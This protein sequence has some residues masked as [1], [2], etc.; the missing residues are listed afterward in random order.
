MIKQG[1][2]LPSLYGERRWREKMQFSSVGGKGF[3]RRVMTT[4]G[5][6]KPFGCGGW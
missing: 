3:D 5:E 6:V 2:N 1:R 4:C